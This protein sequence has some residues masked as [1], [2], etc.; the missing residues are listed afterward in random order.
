MLLSTTVSPFQTAKF[1][2]EIPLAFP[3]RAPTRLQLVNKQENRRKATDLLHWVFW[4]DKIVS[5]LT[6]LPLVTMQEM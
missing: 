3:T 4:Q 1:E 2:L 6:L 5:L